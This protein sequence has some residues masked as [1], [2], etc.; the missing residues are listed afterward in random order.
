MIVPHFSC[1]FSFNVSPK[2]FMLVSQLS[3]QSHNYHVVSHR[4]NVSPTVFMLVPQFSCQSNS[5]YVSSRV[6]LLVPQFPCYSFIFHKSPTVFLV[7][8]QVSW[9]SD[10]SYQNHIQVRTTIFMSIVPQFSYQSHRIHVSPKVSCW[11]IS[12]IL[13]E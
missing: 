10:G 3:C 12:L 5:F 2:V 6:L 9:Q 1:Q 8:S 4:F 7:P 11:F 13:L